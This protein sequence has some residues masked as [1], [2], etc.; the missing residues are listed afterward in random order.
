MVESS[1]N[2][3]SANK[4]KVDYHDNLIDNLSTKAD[5]NEKRIMTIDSNKVDKDD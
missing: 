5:N 4:A 2:D 1:A 3:V